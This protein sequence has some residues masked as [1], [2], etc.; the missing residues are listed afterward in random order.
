LPRGLSPMAFRPPAGLGG[1]RLRLMALT[2]TDLGQK[3]SSLL[4]IRTFRVR[5]NSEVFPLVTGG[6]SV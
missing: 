6:K 5:V 1:Q 4:P 3:L 2:T